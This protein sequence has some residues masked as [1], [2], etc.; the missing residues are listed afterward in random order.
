MLFCCP[1]SLPATHFLVF[2]LR[3]CKASVWEMNCCLWCCFIVVIWSLFC[4]LNLISGETIQ[5]F[6]IQLFEESFLSREHMGFQRYWSCCNLAF[7]NFFYFCIK[8]PPISLYVKFLNL[9]RP[10]QSKCLP[11]P[12]LCKGSHLKK[13]AHKKRPTTYIKN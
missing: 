5:V 13:V 2:S 9:Q 11:T 7:V 3:K 12:N 4:H 1:L 10:H 6:L 8:F